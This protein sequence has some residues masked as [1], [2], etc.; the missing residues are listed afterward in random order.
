MQRCRPT[1]GL[2]EE[3]HKECCKCRQRHLCALFAMYY[4]RI[5]ENGFP[6]DE[7]HYSNRRIIAAAKSN[8]K[9]KRKR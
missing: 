1:D 4:G 6:V 9:K 5:D 7:P 8:R 3:G 2:Y